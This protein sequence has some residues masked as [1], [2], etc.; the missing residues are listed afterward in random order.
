MASPIG[1][2]SAISASS[3]ANDSPP[4]AASLIAPA[5]T[6]ARKAVT[7]TTRASHVASTAAIAIAQP[8][9]RPSTMLPRAAGDGLRR[10]DGHHRGDQAGN[11]GVDQGPEA[12]EPALQRRVAAGW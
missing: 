1:I 11:E 2:R 10:A 3:T 7:S 12:V 9:G 4:S 8:I 6:N 5:R